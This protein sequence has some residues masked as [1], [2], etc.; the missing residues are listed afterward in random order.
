MHSHRFCFNL[1]FL[2]TCFWTIRKEK[3]NEGRLCLIRRE[4][5]GKAAALAGGH[6]SRQTAY[7]YEKKK[8]R[9]G[10]YKLSSFS[11]FAAIRKAEASNVSIPESSR[12]EYQISRQN[13]LTW[14]QPMPRTGPTQATQPARQ[15]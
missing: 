2:N 6:K 9:A 13:L 8:K 5:I 11:H 4:I 12:V 7:S 15:G 10:E 1:T 3:K 14:A